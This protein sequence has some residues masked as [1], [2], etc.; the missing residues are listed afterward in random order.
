MI[1]VDADV[2]PAL[3]NRGHPEH[4]RCVEALRLLQE[5]LGTVWPALAA[6]LTQTAGVPAA[7]S[8]ILEMVERGS[9][10]LVELGRDDMAA[11]RAM[12][13]RRGVRPLSLVHAALFRAAEREG[14][15]TF[16]TLASAALATRRLAGG[17]RPRLIPDGRRGSAMAKALRKGRATAR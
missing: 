1:L 14:L 15:D 17:R 5:P 2:L 7:E 3:V 8:A 6:A 4:R 13:G 16:F 12:L 10:R 9:L 11:L